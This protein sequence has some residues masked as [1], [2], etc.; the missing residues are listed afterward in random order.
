MTGEHGMAIDDF[1]MSISVNPYQS[2]SYYSRALAWFELGDTA[3]AFE[4]C[5]SA[6]N[7][8]PES[9]SIRSFL[10]MVRKKMFE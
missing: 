1:N 5:T 9:A 7:F 8:K 2:E 3:R 10:D 6:L 4:D